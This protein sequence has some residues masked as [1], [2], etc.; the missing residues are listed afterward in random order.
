MFHIAG[1]VAS[2]CNFL[3]PRD[4]WARC[5]LV[6]HTAVQ[7]SQACKCAKRRCSNT[8]NR[9]N[10]L[11]VN[12]LRWQFQVIAAFQWAG[13][14]A[15]T[16]NLLHLFS[17]NTSLFSFILIKNNSKGSVVNT[18]EVKRILDKINCSAD[19]PQISPVTLFNHP[20]ALFKQSFV[21]ALVFF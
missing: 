8:W 16:F 11:S 1:E 19:L 6:C 9:L 20:L 14:T 12:S 13:D 3:G 4:D 15:L 17:I 7:H 2:Y 21:V 5:S 10:P 18:L